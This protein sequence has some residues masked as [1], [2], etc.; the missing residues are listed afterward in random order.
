MSEERIILGVGDGRR[1][2]KSIA[3]WKRLRDGTNKPD[4]GLGGSSCALCRHYR[5]NSACLDKEGHGCPLMRRFGE[6]GSWSVENPYW[7]AFLAWW[8]LDSAGAGLDS[9]ISAANRMIE[10]LE[11]LLPRKKAKSTT[12]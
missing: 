4:E 5:N 9:W 1:I 6:C 3:H 7:S 11:S 2:R 8:W 12:A 10:A